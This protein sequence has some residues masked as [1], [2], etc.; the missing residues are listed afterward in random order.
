MF[1]SVVKRYYAQ[2]LGL[3]R[4]QVYVISIMPCTAKKF[5]AGREEFF[6]ANNPDVDLVLTTQELI[7][8]IKEAG[9]DFASLEPTALDMPFGFATGAGVIFGNSGGVSEAVLRNAYE[10]V[11]KEEL[12]NVV[13]NDVRGHEGVRDF[14]ADLKGTEIKVAIVNGLAN[15][16]QLLEDIK[17]G[18][19]H[20]DLVEV[21]ACP[22]GCVGGA[23][24]LFLK[25][26]QIYVKNGL[27][28]YT[29]DQRLQMHKSQ[30]NPM[31][32]SLYEQWLTEPG[33]EEAH[34]AL[35]TE[36][37]SRRRID[38]E[39]IKINQPENAPVDIQVCV[40]TCYLKGSVKF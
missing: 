2:D 26:V 22:G 28:V 36:Y 20:Y 3:D 1:G 12:Q 21:M 15:A 35:H 5:E 38:T 27:K 19:A 33:S 29:E 24:R 23:G 18:K 40:G 16:R 32:T 7:S 39:A 11:T 37:G 6:V 25:T 8:M 31:L 9:I 10:I 13:F 34:Q 30:Q 14:T 4:E 17:S